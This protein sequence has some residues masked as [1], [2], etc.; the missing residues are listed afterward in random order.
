MRLKWIYIGLLII[1]F[2]GALSPIYAQKGRKNKPDPKAWTVG[3]KG[4]ANIY[5]GD[6]KYWDYIPNTKYG[7]ITYGGAISLGK[8]LSPKYSITTDLG[9]FALSGTKRTNSTYRSFDTKYQFANINFNINLMQVMQRR[10]KLNRLSA[11]ANIGVGLARWKSILYD[12]KTLDTLNM[13]YWGEK[14][15]LSTLA[16]PAGLHLK[17][18]INKNFS[19]DAH[20]S[21][22]FVNS[23]LLDAKSGGNKIDYFWHTGLGINY[24]FSLQRS[25]RRVPLEPVKNDNEIQILDF[26]DVDPFGDPEMKRITKKEMLNQLEEKEQKAI[27][28]SNPYLVE[29][30]VP[31]MANN[32]KFKILVRIAKRGITGNGFFRLNLPSGFYPV[33]PGIPEVTYTRIA[34]QF[35]FDFYLPMNK[36]TLN[37]P[38]DI[39][40]SERGNGTYPIFI[41]GEVMNQEGKLFPIKIAQYVQIGDGIEYNDVPIDAPKDTINV[42]ISEDEA[43]IEEDSTENYEHSGFITNNSTETEGEFTWRI[44]ILACR[45]P[46]PT[47]DEFMIDHQVDQEVYVHESAGWY[48]YNLFA[49]ATRDEAEKYLAEVKNRYRIPE[50][51]IVKF[52]NGQRIE[53]KF[54]GGGSYYDDSND[55]SSQS[56]SEEDTNDFA[57]LAEDDGNTKPRK[58]PVKKTRKSKKSSPA[59]VNNTTVDEDENEEMEASTDG[60]SFV[61]IPVDE[62]IKVFRVEIVSAPDYPIPIDQIQDWVENEKVSE[63][64]QGFNYRYTIGRFENEQVAR[65]FLQYVQMQFA[66]PDAHLVETK[67]RTWLKMVP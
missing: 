64:T 16:V 66:L 47:V 24:H 34:Y 14:K 3:L 38:I 35:D 23:D 22:V 29:L 37:I 45:Q 57:D 60:S 59:K 18:F 52:K 21:L 58:V 67:S 49:A 55:N 53:P 25:N 33:N 11:W 28:S 26:F 8:Y 41:E 10:P 62:D 6:I 12:T 1:A 7:E 27:S 30:W 46:C 39:T 17:Y 9:Y 61:P 19:L 20:S 63:W 2:I 54:S 43:V 32:K 48:R 4:G 15:Y 50:A 13:V 36:D 65:A 31:Q 40:I 56:Y 42:D 44:Q 5:F 51:F